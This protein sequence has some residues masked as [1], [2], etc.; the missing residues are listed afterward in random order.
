M[1]IKRTGLVTFFGGVAVRAN[2]TCF[3]SQCQH[4]SFVVLLVSITG[5]QSVDDRIAMNAGDSSE[6]TNVASLADVPPNVKQVGFNELVTEAE[7]LT[8]IEAER[9]IG[10]AG[11]ASGIASLPSTGEFSIA[12]AESLAM[13]SHPALAEAN[14]KV[15]SI[16]GQYVQA[17]LPFNPVL[18]YQSDEI[19]NDDS[20]GLHSLSVSQQFVTG[21]KLG[22]GQQVQAQ[23]L[24]KQQATL[25]T[26]ELRVLTR[27]RASFAQA[28]VA[29]RRV[30]IT[31]QIVD[32]AEK[33][34]NSVESLLEAEEVSK[35]ALLQ[36]RVEAEQVR[37]TKQN[38]V[39]QLEASRR[40]LAAAIGSMLPDGPLVGD[41]DDGLT[42]SPWEQ[43]L[44]EITAAS[45][46]MAEAGSELER[47]R[48]ALQLACAQVIPNITGQVGVG[49]DTATDDTFAR[50]GVSMPLPIR[51]RNQGNIRTARANISAA[52]A[53]ID[54]TRLSLESR[55]AEALGRYQIAHE[56]YERINSRVL[57][58][59]EETYRL[60]Q[61]A[62][63]AG[64]TDYLQLLTAQRTLFN[65]QL[66]R[67]DSAAQAR[68]AI[69]DIEG[70]L[71]GD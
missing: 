6:I 40:G 66:S 58:N 62:F 20:S 2:K 63:D 27:V 26:T 50:I 38:A 68:K 9:A 13:A 28:L 56:R 59:A 32:L 45:P 55:L 44:D 35:V 11:E 36:A 7:Q 34:I 46:E 10:S 52:S 31:S 14:S 49:V 18:Q 64:E 69:A 43:L 17:G 19:G 70:Y 24:Q 57:P 61:T 12:D 21:N 25:K 53:A 30:E 4:L 42:E 3:V 5:C 15:D 37:I 8:V 51:N 48:W 16:R 65:T 67:L 71:V 29:Q 33:S 41:I 22:I 1:P 39:T 23:A 60:S 47:A 54:R